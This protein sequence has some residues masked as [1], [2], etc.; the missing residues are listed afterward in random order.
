MTPAQRAAIAAALAILRSAG[1]KAEWMDVHG[2]GGSMI[3]LPK[4]KDNGANNE[5]S[6]RSL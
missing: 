5:R 6:T 4:C 2:S 3:Y 1:I